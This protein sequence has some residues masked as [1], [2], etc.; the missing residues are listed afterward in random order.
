MITYIDDLWTISCK[1]IRILFVGKCLCRDNF[2][3]A[4]YVF[5]NEKYSA[6]KAFHF[7]FIWA[8]AAI[9][10]KKSSSWCGAKGF[11]VPWS[12]F[13]WLFLLF[14]P[15]TMCTCFGIPIT[16]RSEEC[17]ALIR[18][19]FSGTY[20]VKSMASEVS[21]TIWTTCTE[22]TKANTRTSAFISFASPD[23]FWS[24][25]LS[26]KILWSNISSTSKERNSQAWSIKP[27]TRCSEIIRSFWLAMSGNRDALRS[28]Q[29]SQTH[30]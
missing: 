26:S 12:T 18:G 6:R 1:R 5:E 15:C 19:R 16:G 13:S 10:W 25:L 24:I 23:Y 4:P 14:L 11:A 3:L 21:F 20:K 29:R 2:G 27:P 7:S 9:G 22:S 28:H 8:S 17:S 30:V